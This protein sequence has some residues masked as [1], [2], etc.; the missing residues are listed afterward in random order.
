MII[1][2]RKLYSEFNPEQREY[3]II[4]DL[5][6][7]GGKRTVKKY[8]GRVRRGIGNKLSQ[9][10][11]DV[12]AD[13][14]IKGRKTNE[15]KEIDPARGNKKLS[16]YLLKEAND[17][18]IF[19]RGNNEI[20]IHL[21]IPFE[22]RG[23]HIIV[24]NS[25]Q[26][27][28]AGNNLN[29]P[30]ISKLMGNEEK[31]LTSAVRHK[32]ALINLKGE[33]SNNP[34]ILAHEIGHYKNSNGVISSRIKKLEKSL[35]AKEPNLKNSIAR[36]IIEPLE[37]TNANKKAVRMMKSG[38]ATENEIKHFK[39]LNKLALKTHKR[40]RDLDILRNLIKKIQIPSRVTQ[41]YV[42][43]Q[44]KQERE[45]YNKYVLKRKKK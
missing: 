6:H 36:R 4:E 31:E 9:S 38:G 34:G 13:L 1:L 16:N 27:E 40:S 26:R 8:V 3:N 12:G 20:D 33:I 15:L 41:K 22:Q 17:E 42:T 18:N 10:F 11:R 25:K 28:V 19:V 14:K 44:T 35:K 21:G 30:F 23:D 24:P 45:F 2:K 43:P 7:S 5:Y 32:N 29:N 37:E 39:K